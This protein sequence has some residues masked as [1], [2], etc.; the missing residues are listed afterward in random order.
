MKDKR[1]KNDVR[2]GLYLTRSIMGRCTILQTNIFT[3]FLFLMDLLKILGDV[4]LKFQKSDW[5]RNIAV[6]NV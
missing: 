1:F 6:A 4:S 3:I 5:K 2:E